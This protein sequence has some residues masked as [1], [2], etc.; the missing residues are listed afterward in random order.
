MHFCCHKSL[1]VVRKLWA[2]DRQ[3]FSVYT[4]VARILASVTRRMVP[5]ATNSSLP[6]SEK[7]LPGPYPEQNVH[8]ISVRSSLIL[9]SHL[10]R[11]FTDLV[12]CSSGISLTL[13]REA[14][15][16][17]GHDAGYANLEFFGL[18]QCLP[19][20]VGIVSCPLPATALLTCC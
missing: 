10:H 4:H 20:S 18:I 8:H 16:R 17:L 19:A 3:S 5:K 13:F 6:C 11:C 14:P 1:S 9:S 7:S 12:D 15:V 2:N